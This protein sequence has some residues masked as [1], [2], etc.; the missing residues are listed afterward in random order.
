MQGTFLANQELALLP[1]PAAHSRL[2]A[3]EF[4]DQ[5]IGLHFRV[6]SSLYSDAFKAQPS[7]YIADR[8]FG[9]RHSPRQCKQMDAESEG[10]AAKPI[11]SQ[12]EKRF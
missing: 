9:E 6:S 11:A 7:D 10:T 3:A 1:K 12:H 2:M 5:N 4:A 8:V